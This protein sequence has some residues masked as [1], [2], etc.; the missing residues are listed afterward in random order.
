MLLRLLSGMHAGT[1]AR[2]TARIARGP[3]CV[4]TVR[5][6]EATVRRGA[7]RG[8]QAR[9]RAAPSAAALP[10]T[11]R[12]SNVSVIPPAD[13]RRA[14]RIKPATVGRDA[15]A[16]IRDY[17]APGVLTRARARAIIGPCAEA[18]PWAADSPPL[19]TRPLGGQDGNPLG[20]SE[21]QPPA[22]ADDGLDAREPAAPAE[23][24]GAGLQRVRALHLH[25]GEQ[26]ALSAGAEPAPRG[27]V[28]RDPRGA[29]GQAAGGRARVSG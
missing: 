9:V 13:L 7:K 5:R 6:L 3:A 19:H 12:A 16:T 24:D 15:P 1:N 26:R 17:S 21:D 28:G 8:L 22:R 29:E 27:V 20:T 4:K 23:G 14:P 18:A 2:C 25:A 11:A 10:P